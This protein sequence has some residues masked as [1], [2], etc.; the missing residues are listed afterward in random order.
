MNGKFAKMRTGKNLIVIALNLYYDGLSLRKTQRNLEQI[1]GETVSQVTILNWIKK[2]SKV[3]K[4][5]VMTLT[6]QLSG[7]WHEDETVLRCEGRNI[8]F[9]EMIDEDTRFLV[10]SHI[11]GTRT[12]QDTIAIF[13]RGY[14]QSKVRPR[15]VFVDGSHVYYRAFTKVFWTMRKDTRPELV[16]RVGIRTRETNNMVERLHGTLKDR[17]KPM[18]G[19]KSFE[20]TKSILE[21]YIIHYNYVRPHQSLNGKTPAQAARTQAPNNWKNLIEQATKH[22]AELLAKV[23]KRIEAKEG[24]LIKV[25]A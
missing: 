1:F 13:K 12:L 8:W 17:T 6:P 4:E 14:E 21:G 3:V 25:I 19:F 23:T 5:F 2:Y 18:R 11:S 24:E 7:L 22:E 16:R 20:S 9:W 15:A 10:A